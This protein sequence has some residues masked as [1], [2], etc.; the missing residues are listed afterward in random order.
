MKKRSTPQSLN[1][2]K[3]YSAIAASLMAVNQALDAQIIYTDINPDY[4]SNNNNDVYDLDLNNDGT[5]DFKI[6]QGLGS[7]VNVVNA[8]AM[9]NNA[10]GGSNLSSNRYP[11]VLN[12]ND[13]INNTAPVQWN[14]GTGQFMAVN[15][16]GS[17][18]QWGNWKNTPTD[19]YMALKLVVSSQTYY[20]WARLTITNAFPFTIKDYAYNGTPNQQILAGVSVGEEEFSNNKNV[21]IKKCGNLI[22]IDVLHPETEQGFIT[23]SNI[24]GEELKKVEIKNNTSFDLSDMQTGVYFVSV[25]QKD[26]VIT[27]K[28]Y[29]Y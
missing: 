7:N 25:V 17:S 8:S 5:I 14:L 12:A 19:K 15:N 4:T 1:R 9:G 3:S 20:G 13:P 10:I 11:F 16:M 28:I 27:E 23:V 24:L 22:K 6:H 18:F 26:K 2:L 21:V 29:I